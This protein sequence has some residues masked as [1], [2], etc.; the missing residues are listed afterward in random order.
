MPKDPVNEPPQEEGDD[1][2]N[3]P[4]DVEKVQEHEL[5]D[6]TPHGDDEDDES[7]S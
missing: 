5:E 4:D 6:V 7:E 2:V 3:D 1:T